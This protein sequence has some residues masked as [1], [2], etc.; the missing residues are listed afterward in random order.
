MDSLRKIR[1]VLID[2]SHPGNIGSAARAM[3]TMGLTDLCLVNPKEFPHPQATSLASNAED[4][5]EQATVVDS[6]EAAIA[7]CQF[8]LGTSSRKRYLQWPLIESRE[9]GVEALQ[10][11]QLGEQVAIL[12]GNE[13][14]GLT[15]AQLHLCHKHVTIPTSSEHSSLNLAQAVQV[16]A[17][18]CQIAALN[19]SSDKT[20]LAAQRVDQVIDIKDPLATDAQMQ[21]LYEHLEEA[22]IHIDF[23]NPNEKKPPMRRVKRLFQRAQCLDSEVNI[24][25]GICKHILKR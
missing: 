12:F 9:G 21:G 11:A 3:K 25:R 13:R 17:Y 19:H 6:V 2:T 24:L 18:E 1:I 5:L 8:V 16:L 23:V 14:I 7:N 15:N 4:I 20:K 10:H 22:L